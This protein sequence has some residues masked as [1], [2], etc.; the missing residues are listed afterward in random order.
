MVAK[1]AQY[2][3][4]LTL[5]AIAACGVPTDYPEDYK[6]EQIHFGQGGGISGILNYFVL[7]DDGRMFQRAYS[8]STFA[9]IEIWEKNFVNQMFSNYHALAINQLD[10][11]EPGD[12][13]YFLQHKKGNSPF[14]SIAWGKPGFK[15]DNNVLTYYNILYNSTKP[16]S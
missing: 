13:Y 2:L 7:L 3:V 11:Y 5:L 14:H 1:Y 12:L 10:Y 15:P 9:L 16:K 6:G 8:D 4:F